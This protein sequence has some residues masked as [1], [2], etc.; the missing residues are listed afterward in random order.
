MRHSL[1]IHDCGKIHRRPEAQTLKCEQKGI[2]LVISHVCLTLK[3]MTTF[4][5]YIEIDVFCAKQ[6]RAIKSLLYNTQTNQTKLNMSLL[7]KYK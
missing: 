4:Y 3:L 1:T 6:F 5:K 7:Q 2:G